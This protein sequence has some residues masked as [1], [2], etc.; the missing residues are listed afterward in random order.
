MTQH[1]TSSADNSG[2]TRLE[3]ALKLRRKHKGYLAGEKSYLA[4]VCMAHAWFHGNADHYWRHHLFLVLA[5]ALLPPSTLVAKLGSACSVA[6]PR[7]S[8]KVY[9]SV[10]SENAKYA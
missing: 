5:Y 10:I 8:A 3:Y 6:T 4:S 2:R 7:R 9:A 1:K